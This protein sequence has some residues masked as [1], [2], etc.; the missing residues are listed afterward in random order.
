MY[1][2]RPHA[3]VLARVQKSCVVVCMCLRNGIGARTRAEV[4]VRVNPHAAKSRRVCV[5][6]SGVCAYVHAR[7]HIHVSRYTSGILPVGMHRRNFWLAEHA[8]HWNKRLDLCRSLMHTCGELAWVVAQVLLCFC[9]VLWEK[10][11]ACRV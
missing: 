5:L 3:R 7:A 9:Q 10:R 1:R 8:Y 6:N 2:A 4:C 11:M